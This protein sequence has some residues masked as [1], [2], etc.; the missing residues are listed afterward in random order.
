MKDANVWVVV[1]GN[2]NASE[3]ALAA[4]MTPSSGCR[5]PYGNDCTVTMMQA[6]IDRA[7]SVMFKCINSEIHLQQ[8]IYDIV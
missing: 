5:N 2:L 6:T 1:A 7:L 4:M 3:N 8:A